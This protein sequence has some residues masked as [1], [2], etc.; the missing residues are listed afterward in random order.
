MVV[1]FDY[2]AQYDLSRLLYQGIDSLQLCYS[3]VNL[4]YWCSQ[5]EP[6]A[7]RP[8]FIAIYPLLQKADYQLITVGIT[9]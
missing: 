3:I 5:Y 2:C 6:H 1:H 4:A 9:P 8:W 7:R